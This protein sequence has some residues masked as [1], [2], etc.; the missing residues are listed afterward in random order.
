MI[1]LSRWDCEPTCGTSRVIAGQQINFRQLPILERY[2][3]GLKIAKILVGKDMSITTLTQPE[4]LELLFEL[5]DLSDASEDFFDDLSLQIPVGV[6]AFE[7]NTEGLYTA[8]TR[9]PLHDSR[10][11]TIVK[12]NR[13]AADPDAKKIA[14]HIEKYWFLYRPVYSDLCSFEAMFLDERFNFAHIH[15]MHELLDLKQFNEIVA[16]TPED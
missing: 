4:M 16:N 6:T 9:M 1:D 8:G 12:L 14:P 11:K 13:K 15:W 2:D 5:V 7:I 3:L 10:H